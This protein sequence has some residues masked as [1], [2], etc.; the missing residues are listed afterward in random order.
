MGVQCIFCP[1]A[2][3]SRNVKQ[4]F[5]VQECAEYSEMGFFI[6]LPIQQKFDCPVKTFLST[7]GDFCTEP[8]RGEGIVVIL[9]LLPAGSLSVHGTTTPC[10]ILPQKINL[11]FSSE[12][13][14]V[15]REITSS[16]QGNKT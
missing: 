2:L 10:C 14:V 5:Y 11:I 9:L 3:F 13:K 12:V 8:K 1:K 4:G 15:L 7:A 16:T 6:F